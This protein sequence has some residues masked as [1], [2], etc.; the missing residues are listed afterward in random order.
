MLHF[1]AGHREGAK[2]AGPSRSEVGSSAGK[3]PRRDNSRRH[4]PPM[5][6][7]PQVEQDGFDGQAK[8]AKSLGWNYMFDRF[9][10]MRAMPFNADREGKRL[11]IKLD[12][13]SNGEFLLP[14]H[15]G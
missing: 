7:P 12:S 15:H 6:Y 13:T 5:P 11:P 14:P 10:R 1:G 9:Q 3:Q 2:S 8:G 4:A